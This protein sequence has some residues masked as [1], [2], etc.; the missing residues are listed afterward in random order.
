MDHRPAYRGE[1]TVMTGHTATPRHPSVLHAIARAWSYQQARAILAVYASQE[2]A[3]NVA[4]QL[5]AA[6]L[7]R[8]PIWG[9][10]RRSNGEHGDP[11][12]VVVDCGL[13]VD[14]AARQTWWTDRHARA[15]Q[16]L[17]W[18][19]DQ[20]APGIGDPLRRIVNH[21]PQLQ[22]GTARV[23]TQHLADEE[24]WIREA[25]QLPADEHVLPGAE[26]PKCER[27]PLYVRTTGTDL[28]DRVVVCGTECRCAG[29]G[30]GCGMLAQVEG[31][32]HVWDRG[33]PAI[34]AMLDR[35][36]MDARGV[37]A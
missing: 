29:V 6:H 32:V 20:L 26:C 22:P 37:A 23:I 14:R 2:T 31:A 33:T 10:T 18:I 27:R 30:C 25:L 11:T 19:A 24:Y 12:G 15:E 13:A 16:R 35:A 34:A 8:S 9:G 5:P 3:R 36:T 7:L 17:A 21:I 4:E 1:P 28:A